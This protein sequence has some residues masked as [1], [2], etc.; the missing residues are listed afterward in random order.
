MSVHSKVGFDRYVALPKEQVYA[1]LCEWE[2]PGSWLPFTRVVTADDGTFTA[3][4]GFGPFLLRSGVVVLERDDRGQRV[5]VELTG[6][7]LKG[8][9]EFAVRSFSSTACIVRWEVDARVSPLPRFLT[10]LVNLLVRRLTIRSL[11]R[12]LPR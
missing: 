4:T 9:A 5:R 2:R 7:A 3:L 12:L 1:L 11:R 10:P 8:T 6:P